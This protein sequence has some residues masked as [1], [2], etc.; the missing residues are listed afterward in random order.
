[1]DHYNE[2]T[3]WLQ[4]FLD[5]TN[6]ELQEDIRAL[7]HIE[8]GIDYRIAFYN[9]SV[10]IYNQCLASFPHSLF[11]QWLNLKPMLKLMPNNF[12]RKGKS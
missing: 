6:D 4:K 12:L 8:D 2:I 5:H 3:S 7:L 10:E 1:I 11:A 9:D